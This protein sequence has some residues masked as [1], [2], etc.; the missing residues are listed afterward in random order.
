MSKLLLSGANTSSK[1]NSPTS[2]Y[3]MVFLLVTSQVS[4][5]CIWEGLGLIVTEI[6]P[7]YDLYFC[8]GLLPL[9]LFFTKRILPGWENGSDLEDIDRTGE[10]L[11]LVVLDVDPEPKCGFLRLEKVEI[12]FTEGGCGIRAYMILLLVKW[13]LTLEFFLGLRFSIIDHQTLYI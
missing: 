11:L 8:C 2:C 4:L 10:L 13:V 6:L 7:V 5:S 9:L 1:W 3:I 12:N